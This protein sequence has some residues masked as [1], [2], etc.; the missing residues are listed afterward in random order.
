LWRDLRKAP[1]PRHTAVPG[2]GVAR[3]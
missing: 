2:A 3:R 1:T